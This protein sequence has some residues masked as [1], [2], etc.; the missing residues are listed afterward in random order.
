L[1]SRT[2][3]GQRRSRHP[4]CDLHLQIGSF[5]FVVDLRPS[6]A[7][8]AIAGAIKRLESFKKLSPRAGKF[9]PVVAVPYM[10]E[11]GKVLCE[12]AGIGWIDLSGN[13]RL[14]VFS[15]ATAR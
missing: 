12:K 5:D 2:K 14:T 1:G 6:S 9:I 4:A 7:T 10:G 8:E 13:A 15:R 3:V 11:V